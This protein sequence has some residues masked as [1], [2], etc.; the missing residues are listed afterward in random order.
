[1]REKVGP[2]E[3]SR[4]KIVNSPRTAGRAGGAFGARGT[5]D[6]CRGA[7]E[8][9]PHPLLGPSTS[10]SR[11]RTA[12]DR[13]GYGRAAAAAQ[14]RGSAW[15]SPSCG[16]RATRMPCC[17]RLVFG[18]QLGCCRVQLGCSDAPVVRSCRAAPRS[19]APRQQIGRQNVRGPRRDA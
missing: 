8:A 1:M 13:P 10:G 7:A 12:R 11:A 3:K 5:A 17:V 18:S 2:H 4:Q 19:Y 16:L 15:P 14:Q 9:R 6:V